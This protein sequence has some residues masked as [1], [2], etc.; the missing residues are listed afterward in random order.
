MDDD[1]DE[2]YEPHEIFEGVCPLP[3]LQSNK[4]Q[5]KGQV[6]EPAPLEPTGTACSQSA[7]AVCRA[8]CRGRVYCISLQ[9]LGDEPSPAGTGGFDR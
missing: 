7:T 6:E 5:R 4:R 9:E 3:G 8:A 1:D 2:C